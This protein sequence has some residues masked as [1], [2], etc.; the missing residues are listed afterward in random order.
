MQDRIRQFADGF[1]KLGALVTGPEFHPPVDDSQIVE[2]ESATGLKLPDDFRDFVTNHCGGWNFHWSCFDL[3]ED[4]QIE[5]CSPGSPFGGNQYSHFVR[6]ADTTLLS[7]YEGLVE[8]VSDWVENGSVSDEDFDIVRCC[9]PLYLC[10]LGSDFV[11]LRLDVEPAEVVYLDHEAGFHIESS[12]VLGKGFSRFL[13]AY[14][15]T[16]C[17]DLDY[18]IPIYNDGRQIDETSPIITRWIEAFELE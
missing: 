14:T 3:M 16:G 10:I 15:Q 7:C 12:H 1:I 13:R 6:S 5:D 9:Y 17:P 2:F 8:D 18:H 4:N 11:G